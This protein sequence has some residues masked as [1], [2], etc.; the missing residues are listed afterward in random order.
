V[1]ERR[2]DGFFYGLFMDPKILRS[3]GVEPS[4][5]RQAF[6]DQF[7]LRIGRRATLVPSGECRAYGMVISLTHAELERLYTAPGL[8]QYRPEAVIAHLMTGGE[9][10]ALCY[11][12]VVQPT[13]D[14]RN[15]DYALRLQEVLRSLNFPSAYVESVTS[16][17]SSTSSVGT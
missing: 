10:P 13:V 15:P 11:N 9:V 4:N 17:N 12:L 16:G 2:I 7:A 1:G 6:V 14:E 8:E 5:I 3:S